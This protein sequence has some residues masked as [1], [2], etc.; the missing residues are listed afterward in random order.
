MHYWT[1]YMH[2]RDDDATRSRQQLACHNFENHAAMDWSQLPV[3]TT[4]STSLALQ[5]SGLAFRSE[6]RIGESN[7]CMHGG[8]VIYAYVYRQSKYLQ[9]ETVHD[10]DVLSCP[11]DL[12]P[13]NKS[14]VH[15]ASLSINNGKSIFQGV[16]FIT[17][18]HAGTYSRSYVSVAHL[19]EKN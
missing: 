17:C 13:G 7:K 8:R 9:I 5:C 4:L 15:S 6:G 12:C 18:K 11:S 1:E 10:Q 14:L 3:I 16:F 2:M 19:T